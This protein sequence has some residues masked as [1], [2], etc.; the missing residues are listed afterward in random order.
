MEI[1]HELYGN[2]K[3]RSVDDKVNSAEEYRDSKY[4]FCS[5]CVKKRV[6]LYRLVKQRESG[7]VLESFI[8]ENRKIIQWLKLI[9]DDEQQVKKIMDVS[10]WTDKNF[11]KIPKNSQ[12]RR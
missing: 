9:H 10:I 8:S 1:L 2:G 6:D 7:V 12:E 11:K 5:R 3:L 4:D